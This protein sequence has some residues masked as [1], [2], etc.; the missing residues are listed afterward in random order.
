MVV[1]WGDYFILFEVREQKSFKFPEVVS[2]FQILPFS[3]LQMDEA[4]QA[5][6]R[7]RRQWVLRSR[8]QPVFS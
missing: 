3:D 6:S 5:C 7:A 8:K 2:K 1:P 4:A